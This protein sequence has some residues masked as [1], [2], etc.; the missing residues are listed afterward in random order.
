MPQN[1]FRFKQFIVFQDQTAMKVTTD[2]CLFGAWCAE[3]IQELHTVQ[4]VLDIGTGTGLLALMTA[5]KTNVLID[6][7]ELNAYAAE[8]AS[9]NCIAS[10]FQNQII[11]FNEDILH[12]EKS[13]YDC[14]I[15]NPPFYQNEIPST[16]KNKNTAHHSD[17]LRWDK[18]F[19]IINEKLSL[20]GVFFLHL[21]YK[22][23]RD[24]E[25]F[26]KKEKLFIN[27]IVFV[28]Q[29]YK[30]KYFRMMIK[31]SKNETEI[32]EKEL[33]IKDNEGTYTKEFTALLCDY[34]LKM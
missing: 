20:V 24:L 23:K 8:Q 22:R 6:A 16:I 26:L 10:L 15:S 18:L 21:P 4:K 12:F 9:Y 11:I 25:L 13:N 2:A 1:F 34:Y 17:G 33:A 3:N 28:K 32:I 19:A 14:I 7:V 27:E 29:T 31:G 30:H 5:Q